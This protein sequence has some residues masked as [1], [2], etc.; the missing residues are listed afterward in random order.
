[1]GGSGDSRAARRR[2]AGGAD[3]CIPGR[4]APRHAGSVPSV[5]RRHALVVIP[6]ALAMPVAFCGRVRAADAPLQCGSYPFALALDLDVVRSLVHLPPDRL[7]AGI[8][9]RG[10]DVLRVP[11]K[12]AAHVPNPLLLA[13]PIAP[14][15]LLVQAGFLDTY[16][17]RAIPAASECCTLVRDT[18]LIR[19]DA[20]TYTLLHEVVHLLIVP[21]DGHAFR[22]DVELRFDTALRRLTVYQRRLC[23][24]PWRLMQPAWRRDILVAQREVAE[25]LYDRLRIGQSQEAV[26]ET[27]LRDCLG[28]GSP[29]FDAPRRD[30]GRRY[31]IAMVDNA[32]DVFNH[33]H[34]SLV[35]CADAVAHLREEVVAGRARQD[36]VDR[37]TASDAVAFAAENQVIRE[38][39]QASREAI[40]VL[41]RFVGDP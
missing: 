26:V 40:E 11:A 13:L 15:A 28:H 8:R 37:L 31:V 20:T 12:D 39:M 5:G 36:A 4:D 2:R 18:V 9:E 24:D 16:Q 3:R 34:A 41:K 35:F 38:R 27:V 30:E 29:Y 21:A 25:L 22:A 6:V 10:I 7:L 33:L 32:V 19:E 14:P 17:G 23:D 1:M